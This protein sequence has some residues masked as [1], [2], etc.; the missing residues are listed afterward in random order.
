MKFMGIMTA[1]KVAGIA[2][3]KFMKDKRI[4]IPG[5]M[6]RVGA[7]ANRFFSRKFMTRVIHMMQAPADRK[8]NMYK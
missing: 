8:E 4:I 1:E 2:Y 6:N 7:F 5:F 3:Q